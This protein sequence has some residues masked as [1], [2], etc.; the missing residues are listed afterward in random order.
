MVSGVFSGAGW[1][2][3]C[4]AVVQCNVTIYLY[5]PNDLR[6]KRHFQK[7]NL[8]SML[9]LIMTLKFKNWISQERNLIFSWNES[10]EMRF[11]NYIFPT[12]IYLFKASNKN[13]SKRCEIYSKFT[14]KTPERRQSCRSYDVNYVVLVLLL[15]TLNIFHTFSTVFTVDF[16]QVN[17][18]WVNHCIFESYRFFS[19]G[20]VQ[21]KKIL[22]RNVSE[23]KKTIADIEALSMCLFID[24]SC[25]SLIVHSEAF[26]QVWSMYLRS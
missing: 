17:V 1:L 25:V 18:T 20:N 2:P 22:K 12:N 11:L 21:N 4:F 13:T 23:T 9:P 16:E 14:I 10:I 7:Y 19:G 6:L 5:G 8:L 24:D 26:T 15:L 3:D